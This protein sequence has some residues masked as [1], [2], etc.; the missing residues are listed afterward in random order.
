MTDETLAV[1]LPWRARLWGFITR[2]SSWR[3][4]GRFLAVGACGYVVNL[5]VYAGWVHALEVEYRASAVAAFGCALATTFVLNRHYT[6][7]AAAGPLGVQ[8]WRYVLVNL[9]GFAT[10][11][12]VLQVLVERAS[13]AKV[14]SEAIAAVAAAPVNFAGLRLWAFARSVVA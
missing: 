3:Q 2:S 6:F 10:N 8:A 13:L 9:L 1:R 7:A 14:P 4:V 5:A 11:L 12:V